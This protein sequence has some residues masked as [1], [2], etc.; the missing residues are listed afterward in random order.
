R[1]LIS[2]DLHDN[3]GAQLTFIISAIENLKY[4]DPIKETL[5]HR[6]DSVANFTKQT[7]T[8]LRDT[9]WAMNS[10]N[11]TLEQLSSRISDYLQRAGISTSGIN[12]EFEVEKGVDPNFTL[13]SSKGIQIYRIVQE[14]IQNSVKYAYPSQVIVSVSSEENGVKVEIKDDGMGFVESEIK[15][16]NGLFNMRKR[17]E[18]LGGSLEISSKAG[19]GTSVSLVLPNNKMI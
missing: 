18:E 17:A 3:I 5:T 9:I 2:R 6:Y 15:L 7:I 11:I 14:A 8:E 1:M 10:G 13:V 4:F 19:K 16:G 12:F